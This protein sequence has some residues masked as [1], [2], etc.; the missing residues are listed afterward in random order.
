[1]TFFETMTFTLTGM[2]GLD[3][4]FYEKLGWTWILS[5]AAL[6]AVTV[7]ALALI[8]IITL[9]IVAVRHSKNKKKIK[10]LMAQS[11]DSESV[12]EAKLRNEL[13]AELEPAIRAE[14]EREYQS[15]QPALNDRAAQQIAKLN[16]EL[17]QKDARIAE[18]EKS[19]ERKVDNDE[20]FKTISD[21]NR[22]NKELQDDVNKLKAETARATESRAARTAKKPANVREPEYDDDDDDEY[23][24]DYGDA[25]SAIKVTLKYDRIKMN[26]VILRSDTDRTYRRVATKQEGL[27]VA[28]D[29]ARRLHAQ[30]VVHKKDG[31]FQ[32]L[33]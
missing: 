23:Y 25:S 3:K 24:D 20:L 22:S 4:I 12:D 9:I 28:K 21:L 10:K 27:P 5:Y 32:K 18:L 31:K 15:T 33:S 13:R 2:S 11:G 1:M 8:L 7:A 30:L 6:L 14:L 16:D 26:W 29:L 17:R 19:S